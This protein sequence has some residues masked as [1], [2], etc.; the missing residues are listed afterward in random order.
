[1]EGRVLTPPDDESG[2]PESDYNDDPL[3]NG[4]IDPTTVPIEFSIPGMA[5]E[6]PRSIIGVGMHPVPNKPKPSRKTEG[7][8]KETQR[9]NHFLSTQWVCGRGHPGKFCH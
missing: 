7:S 8:P 9:P 6:W 3:L 4:L 5:G 2:T 1:M